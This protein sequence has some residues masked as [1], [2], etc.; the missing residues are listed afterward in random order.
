MIQH[1]IHTQS[2]YCTGCKMDIEICRSLLAD[3]EQLATFGQQQ[4]RAHRDCDT[5]ID[6]RMARISRGFDVRLARMIR[7]V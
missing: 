6:P 3:P 1:N 5:Y 2:L 7:S 4:Q